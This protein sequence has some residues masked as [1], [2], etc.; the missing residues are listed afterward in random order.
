MIRGSTMR[1]YLRRGGIF[2]GAIVVALLI[3]FS[4]L[5]SLQFDWSVANVEITM[6]DIVGVLGCVSYVGSQVALDHC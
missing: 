5:Y 1:S 6:L 3:H 4:M 2:I